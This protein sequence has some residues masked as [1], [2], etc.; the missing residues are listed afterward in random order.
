MS[1]KRE[2]FAESNGHRWM[3]Y[4]NIPC[5]KI[6][7]IVRRA[8]DKNKACKGPTAIRLRDKPLLK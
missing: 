7:G 4:D 8:D 2:I 6:C 1:S 3:L 5:C